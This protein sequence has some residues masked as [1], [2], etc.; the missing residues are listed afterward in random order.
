MLSRLR[1]ELRVRG[2]SYRT[3]KTYLYW[4]RRFFFYVRDSGEEARG[5]TVRAE[6]VRNFLTHLAMSG[7]IVRSR[8]Y[9]GTR[10]W[11]RR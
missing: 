5:E 10:A 7:T 6:Q 8:S 3:E 1:E 2:K 4:V 11:R 9:S